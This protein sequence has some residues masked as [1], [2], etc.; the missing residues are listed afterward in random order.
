MY[1]S[2]VQSA[3]L[4]WLLI[5]ICLTLAFFNYP[6]SWWQELIA[7]TAPLWTPFLLVGIYVQLRG[8]TRA[9]FS[10]I[11]IALFSL[12]VLCVVKVARNLAPYLYSPQKTYASVEYSSPMRFLFLDV[13]AR[14]QE[15]SQSSITGL[16]DTKDPDIIIV[17]RDSEKAVSSQAYARYPF[18]LA[19]S[20]DSKRKVEIF[21]KTSL[22]PP[23]K[24]DYGFG[25]LPAVFGVFQTSDG[26]PFQLGGFDLLP[27]SSQENFNESR[28][29]SRRLASALKFSSEPRIA[30]GAFRTS[31]TSQIVEMYVGPLK[32]R[33]VFFNSGF[34]RCLRLIRASFP[35]DR[36]LN[37]FAARKIEVTE[38]KDILS[39]DGSYAA[40]LFTARIPR[41]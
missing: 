20:A 9:A 29:T 5:V 1:R 8:F 10:L 40:I 11:G 41:T 15:R 34:A 36:N 23:L 22:S 32:L 24:T 16:I 28:L 35:F 31:V 6:R 17:A 2:V 21:S 37:V 26:A 38:L 12:Q 18:V 30:V 25:A 33:S 14:G 27:S 19:S 13:S 3:R 39:D 4:V 7:A